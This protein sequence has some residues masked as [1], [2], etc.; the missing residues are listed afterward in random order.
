L[1][2]WPRRIMQSRQ[3]QLQLSEC[4]VWQQADWFPSSVISEIQS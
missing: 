1:Q 3:H 4:S 2:P